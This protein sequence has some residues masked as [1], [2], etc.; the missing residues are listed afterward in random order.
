MSNVPRYPRCSTDT[1]VRCRKK[2]GASDRVQVAMIVDKIGRN[3]TTR[4]VGAFLSEEFELLHVNCTDTTL[5]GQVI[6]P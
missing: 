6:V 4:E 3:P 5:S 1:C 2:L